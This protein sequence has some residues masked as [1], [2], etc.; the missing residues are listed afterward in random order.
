MSSGGGGGGG[1]ALNID[2]NNRTAAP[3]EALRWFGFSAS[4]TFRRDDPGVNGRRGR[5]ART[6]V[7]R[8]FLTGAGALGLLSPTVGYAADLLT[9]DAPSPGQD[10]Y[11]LRRFLGPAADIEGAL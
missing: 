5:R 9:Q 11:G 7:R 3:K 2:R 10:V 4:R 6:L 1:A 8:D